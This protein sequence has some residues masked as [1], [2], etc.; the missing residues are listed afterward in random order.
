[1]HR[2]LREDITAQGY[3]LPDDYD[4]MM[5]DIPHKK[6]KEGSPAFNIKWINERGEEKSMIFVPDFDA[7]PEGI[8]YK[9]DADIK[10]LNNSVNARTAKQAAA[11]E[12]G[13]AEAGNI[14]TDDATQ[15]HVSMKIGESASGLV[16]GATF[17]KDQV[18]DLVED[19]VKM[20]AIRT[21]DWKDKKD[22]ERA[23]RD[24]ETLP[25]MY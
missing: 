2:Q 13:D 12:R 11:I 9:A 25:P 16:T 14:L 23:R 20:R 22:A 5:L 8:K 21:Q 3:A 17:V 19:V 1:M 4:Y 6:A 10:M 18:S 24:L 7:T 15:A